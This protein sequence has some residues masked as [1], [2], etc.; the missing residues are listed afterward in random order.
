VPDDP[1]LR[2]PWSRSD[3]RIPRGLVRPLQEVLRTSTSS[4][5]LLF[6][7]AAGALLWANLGTSYER[8]WTTPADLTIGTTVLGHDLRFWVNDGLMSLFFLVVGIEIKREL[9]VGELR[10]RRVAALPVLAAVGGMVVPALLFLA[11]V[12]GGEGAEGWGIPM[13][14]DI[15]LA[16]GA[17]ALAASRAPTGLKP[18]LLTLA[19]VDDIGAIVV[20]AL[21]YS[22]GIVLGALSAA[23]LVVVAIVLLERA[24]VR[25]HLVYIGLGA[26]LWYATLRAGIPPTIAGVVL[27]LLTP[28]VPFQRPVAVS[29]EARRIADLTSDDPAPDAD[30]EAWLGLAGL[31]REAVSPMARVEH[32]LLPWT[33]FVIVP[34]FALANAGVTLSAASIEHALSSP[35]AWGIVI[36]LVVGKPLGIV[37]ASRAA[38]ATR[39]GVL[40]EQLRWRDVTGLGVTAGIGFTVALFIA[41]LAYADRPLLLDAAIIAILAASLVSGVLGSI[42]VRLGSRRGRR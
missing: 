33:S 2:A 16:L 42:V 29:E 11:V 41:G 5:I 36:G 25:Y 9:T 30:A 35:V 1:D 32:A 20:I 19:I 3:R 17:L 24:H 34:L 27:G 10:D 22:R 38:V 14:T 15:A 13:A 12:R 18:L 21:F 7:A 26:V 6:L 39:V 37:L 4:A 8:F 40:P 23:V 28:S 31:A